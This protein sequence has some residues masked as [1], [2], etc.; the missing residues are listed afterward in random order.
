MKIWDDSKKEIYKSDILKKNDIV[1]ILKKPTKPN[2]T[3]YELENEKKRRN[4]LIEKRKL[5]LKGLIGSIT[6]IDN[7]SYTI[8]FQKSMNPKF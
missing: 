1:Y 2:I 8:S 6:K 5:I 3:Q 4:K 7:N